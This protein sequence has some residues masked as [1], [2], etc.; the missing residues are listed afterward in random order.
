M[1]N[2]CDSMCENVCKKIENNYIYLYIVSAMLLFFVISK[3]NLHTLQKTK[4]TIKFLF[5]FF[6]ANMIYC[7]K[8]SLFV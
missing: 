5:L 2:Y 8:K 7:I 4:R 1:S 6:R 3:I